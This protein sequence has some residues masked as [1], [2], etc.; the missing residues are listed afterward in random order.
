MAVIL[1]INNS[2]IVLKVWKEQRVLTLKDI[3]SIYRNGFYSTHCTALL[4]NF[5]VPM[6]KNVDYF[7][8]SSRDMKKCDPTLEKGKACDVYTLSGFMKLR[9]FIKASSTY[10]PSIVNEVIVRQY[11]CGEDVEATCCYANPENCIGTLFG[12]IFDEKLIEEARASEAELEKIQIQLQEEPDWNEKDEKSLKELEI[13][14]LQQKREFMMERYQLL[15]GMAEETD[16]EELRQ[17]I[18]FEAAKVLSENIDR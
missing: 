18:M 6:T 4:R 1:R 12:E 9:R 17:K 13:Q 10:E 16:D 11:Y 15:K 2:D 14:T 8:L 3:G 5:K 7:A